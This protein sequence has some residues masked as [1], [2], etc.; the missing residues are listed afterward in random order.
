MEA[1][2]FD[3]GGADADDVAFDADANLD[4]HDPEALDSDGEQEVD[5]ELAIDIEET[6]CTHLVKSPSYD[7]SDSTF[8]HQC[9]SS[10]YF[11]YYR[12]TNKCKYSS[13]HHLDVGLSWCPPMWLKRR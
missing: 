11:L 9:I 7:L 13:R 6:Y 4:D 5:E 12:T 1:E 2:D 10:H 8:Q 3:L